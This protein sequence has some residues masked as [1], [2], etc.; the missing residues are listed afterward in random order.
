MFPDKD[1][2]KVI[3]DLIDIGL[4]D[5]YTANNLTSIN[6]LYWNLSR[7]IKTFQAKVQKN[8]TIVI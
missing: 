6:Y 1:E 5:Q 4:Q 7:I 2:V 8:A 3:K